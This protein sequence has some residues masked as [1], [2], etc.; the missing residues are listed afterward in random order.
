MGPLLMAV[1]WYQFWGDWTHLFFTYVVPVVPTVVV[2]D[3]LVSCLRTRRRGEVLRLIEEVDKGLEGVEVSPGW[4]EG[5]RFESGKG[6]HTWPR[7]EANW[8]V[9]V[10]EG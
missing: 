1:S 5:W 4:R 10:R 8:F 2:M 7:G 9:G 6:V 3:G